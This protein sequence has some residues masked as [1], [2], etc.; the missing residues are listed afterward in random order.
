V[1]CYT[2]RVVSTYK[3]IQ[4]IEAEDKLV[5]PLSFRQFVYALI[6]AFLLYLNFISI[7]KHVPFLLV[8]FLPP[9]IFTGFFAF[10]F[11]GDQPTE[12]WAVAK[13]RFLFKPR[14]RIWD[15]SGVKEL[16]TITVPKKIERIYTNGLSQT[17][18]KSRLSA[19]ADTID[20]RGWAIKNV[21]VN[22]YNQPTALAQEGESDRLLGPSSMPQ[23]VSDVDVNASDDILDEQS[24]PVAQ[25]F[26]QLINASSSA[27]RQELINELNGIRQQQAAPAAPLVPISAAQPPAATQWFQPV[28]A[29]AG[30]AAP[31]APAFT[32][33]QMVQPGVLPSA[34]STVV[35]TDEQAIVDR[36]KARNDSQQQ[37]NARLHTLQP[38]SADGASTLPVASA[39]VV[40]PALNPPAETATPT[41]TPGPNAA[42]LNLANNNDLNIATL[43][44]EAQK[45]QNSGSLDGEVV[46]SLR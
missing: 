25:Q 36:L 13:I 44:R 16:V 3:V 21:N 35:T 42:I 17:E 41:G 20:S 15:Q 30:A 45:S 31:A 1:V 11:G 23:A 27:H 38:L 10:P 28:D 7:A 6:C 33:T 46:I 9:A 40:E 26:E 24:N 29:Q 22:M 37:S 2:K 39:T 5:G 8:I 34:Q 43:A 19:L 18:V 32:A 14:K 12:V 4:D